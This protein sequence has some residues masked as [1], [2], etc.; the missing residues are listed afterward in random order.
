MYILKYLEAKYFI[1]DNFLI[2][3]KYT[4]TH[5]VSAYVV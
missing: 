3:I 5:L 1:S 4:F 2:V